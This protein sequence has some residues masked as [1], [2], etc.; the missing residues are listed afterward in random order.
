MSSRGSSRP[1]SN[2]SGDTLRPWSRDAPTI[3]DRESE[4]RKIPLV[5]RRALLGLARSLF[6]TCEWRDHEA[7]V[8]AAWGQPG[9]MFFLTFFLF[10]F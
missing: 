3:K 6:P 5:A 8:S 1:W 4:V 2:G 7:I 10:F 9:A